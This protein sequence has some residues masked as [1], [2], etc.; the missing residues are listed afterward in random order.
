MIGERYEAVNGEVGTLERFT[1]PYGPDN[2]VA[3]LRLDGFGNLVTF[4]WNTL[5]PAPKLDKYGL[6]IE[7]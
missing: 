2:P 6:P 5:R 1:Y 7:P 4:T 3:W